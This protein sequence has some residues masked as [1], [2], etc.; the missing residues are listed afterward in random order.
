ML[1]RH[2][3]GPPESAIAYLESHVSPSINT[4]YPTHHMFLYHEFTRN[5]AQKEGETNLPVVLLV[6]L[7]GF[8]L[9][10]YLANCP[11]Q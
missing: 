6:F 11:M 8:L 3:A 4:Q 2:Q 10:Y 1:P 9:A 7:E 5:V